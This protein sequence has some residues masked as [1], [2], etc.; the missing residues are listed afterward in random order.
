M[1][2]R[3][4]RLHQNPTELGHRT[5]C[6]LFSGSA[7]RH[8]HCSAAIVPFGSRWRVDHSNDGANW[9]YMTFA[10]EEAGSMPTESAACTEAPIVSGAGTQDTASAPGPDMAFDDRYG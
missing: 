7:T 2:C 6:R 5:Q 1:Y 4:I 10:Y 3:P 8:S 9:G